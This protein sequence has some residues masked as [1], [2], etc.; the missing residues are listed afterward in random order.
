MKIEIIKDIKFAI[1]PR[2][3][4]DFIKGQTVCTGDLNTTDI[5]LNRLVE[6]KAAKVFKEKKVKV[7]KNN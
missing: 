4:I 1:N 3:N 6:L 7:E 5:N 2:Q